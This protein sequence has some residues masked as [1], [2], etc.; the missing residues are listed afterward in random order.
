MKTVN[1]ISSLEKPNISFSIEER[2]KRIELNLKKQK[3]FG[4]I[5]S[6]PKSKC[7]DCGKHYLSHAKN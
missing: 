1:K 3:C 7:A 5:S 2:V 6:V 4:F